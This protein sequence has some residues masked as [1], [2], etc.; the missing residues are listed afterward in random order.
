MEIKRARKMKTIPDLSALVE[1]ELDRLRNRLMSMLDEMGLDGASEASPQTDSPPSFVPDENVGQPSRTI[2]PPLSKVNKK[3]LWV[4]PSVE[5]IGDETSKAVGASQAGERLKKKK[6]KKKKSAEKSSEPVDE[7]V[8]YRGDRGSESIN[9]PIAPTSQ[10][11]L[12]MQGVS[13]PH[14][15]KV[16]K[17]RLWVDPSVEPIGDET[18]KAVGASQAG[19]RLK[20]K[21]KKKKKSAEKS[22]EPVD[23][24]VSY[25]GDRGSESINEPIAPTSQTPLSMQGVSPPDLKGAIEAREQAIAREKPQRKVWGDLVNSKEAPEV[26]SLLGDEST[27]RGSEP[28]EIENANLP[29][30]QTEEPNVNPLESIADDVEIPDGSSVPIDGVE[31]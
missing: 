1:E 15:L 8:S 16:N 10:T 14:E 19:E 2:V 20:K 27:P 26:A 11:P 31:D 25:R 13:P 21:K 12:S 6:K 28:I 3:R 23:E 4:D 7:N 30:E 5:P 18:S 22:S 29:T 9:E 24:N 17:K